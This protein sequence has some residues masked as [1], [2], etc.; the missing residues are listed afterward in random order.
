MKRE[1][2]KYCSKCGQENSAD[3]RF[4]QNCSAPLENEKDSE[5]SY[6]ERKQ[7]YAGKIIKCPACG[8]ELPSFTAI[9]PACGHEINSSKISESLD[10]FIA[11]IEE[12][13]RRIANSPEIPKKGWSTWGKWKKIGWVLLNLYL[14][15]IPLLIYVL[16]PLLRT[17]KAPALTADEKYKATI[18]ENFPFPND[19]GSILEALLF[20]KSKVAFLASEKINANNSY[21]MRLWTKK[22][23]QLHEK[24][25][26]LFP[27][28]KIA[29]ETYQEILKD[30]NVVK[31]K[32]RIRL[33]LTVGVIIIFVVFLG[34]RGGK[35][36]IGNLVDNKDYNQKYDWQGNKFTELLPKPESEFGKIIIETE[37]QFS[38]EIYKTSTEMYEEYVKECRSNGF[39][40]DITKT[41]GMFSAHNEEGYQ[42]NIYYYKNKKEMNIS[43]DSNDIEEKGF[44]EGTYESLKVKNFVFDIPDY[45]TEEGSKNEYLQYY[46]EK[47]EKLVMLSIAYPAETDDDYDVSFDGLYKDNENMVEMI[48]SMFTDGDVIDNE[49]F[50]S[51]YGVKG[52]LYRFS[53]N[54]KIGWLKSV[55]ANGYCFCF[56]SEKDRRWFFVYYVQTNKVS[57]NDY[58]DDY[59]K[60]ISC[61]REKSDE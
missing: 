16:R 51:D 5:F 49:V 22:A 14:A 19:R 11:Q 28:D 18:I 13:D 17:D 32:L 34:V 10:K 25:E 36:G 53:C 37:K 1:K 41:E 61:I 35:N 2:R 3:A 54:Q 57:G 20:V 58:K 59:L 60:L 27:G 8:E 24:A 42:L 40:V 33:L 38:V 26:M 43:I 15:C 9:C 7:E 52:I 31:K 6:S 4:C 44:E 21:W 46:A 30:S 48:A 45:W 12:C 50:E 47:G 29:N 23:E 55:D 56:P 39:T